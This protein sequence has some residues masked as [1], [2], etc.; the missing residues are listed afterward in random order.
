MLTIGQRD[1][2]VKGFTH[3]YALV[4]NPSKSYGHLGVPGDPLSESLCHKTKL[5]C[6]AGGFARNV[7]RDLRIISVI[8]HDI[9]KILHERARG[10]VQIHHHCI[11]APP[12]EQLDLVVIDITE[13]ERH[14]AA[15]SHGAGRNVFGAEAQL[16]ADVLGGETKGGGDLDA[17]DGA[18]SGVT[19]AGGGDGGVGCG[20]A[21]AEAA[22]RMTA[23]RA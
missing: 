14:G 9:G 16:V 3:F 6:F 17:G 21:S 23:Q 12:A 5:L 13:E 11:R 7:G 1:L 4:P 20:I 18:P 2:A 19:A 15:G 8:H 10:G 22:D